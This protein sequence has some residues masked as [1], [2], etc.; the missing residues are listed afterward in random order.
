MKRNCLKKGILF[1]VIAFN[2]VDFPTL[3]SPTIPA[4]KAIK[5]LLSRYLL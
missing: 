2:K 4:V 1:L 5:S 3:G